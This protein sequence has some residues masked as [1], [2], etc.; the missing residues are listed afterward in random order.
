MDPKY[1][2][3]YTLLF[4]IDRDF[5]VVRVQDYILRRVARR[6]SPAAG[7]FPILGAPKWGIRNSEWPPVDRF[8]GIEA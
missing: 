6:L 5:R 4:S 7:L 1:F 8:K 2:L 3:R